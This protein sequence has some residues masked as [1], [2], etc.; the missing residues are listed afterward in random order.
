MVKYC[1]TNKTWKVITKKDFHKLV[2][3]WK[4]IRE[5]ERLAK[6]LERE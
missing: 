3:K 6:A 4:I 2:K 1:D 5:T